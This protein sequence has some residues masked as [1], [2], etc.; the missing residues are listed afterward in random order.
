MASSGAFLGVDPGGSHNFGVAMLDG[1]NAT[2]T[3]VS[4]IAGAIARATLE[5]GSKTPIA[6]GIDT[7]LHWCD[8]PGGWRPVDMRLRAAYPAAQSSIISPNSLYGSMGI[9]GMGYNEPDR[10]ACRRRPPSQSPR[11]P[12]QAWSACLWRRS[13]ASSLR[14]CGPSGKR[15]GSLGR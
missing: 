6:A 5:C 8:G 4:S 7:M 2:A 9:G 14:R 3:T 15:E 11:R 13:W 1:I 10:R 12:D